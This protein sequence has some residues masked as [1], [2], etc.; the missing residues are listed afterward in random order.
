[1]RMASFLLT[2]NREKNV[3]KGPSQLKNFWGHRLTQLTLIRSASSAFIC[4]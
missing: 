1:L 4:G 2:N 3:Q